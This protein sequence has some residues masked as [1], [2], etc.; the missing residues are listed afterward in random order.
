M[1]P[2]ISYEKGTGRP[3]IIRPST[4]DCG[5][6]NLSLEGGD[7]QDF[8]QVEVLV[9]PGSRGKIG[10][11][12]QQD[13]PQLGE[14]VWFKR[15]DASWIAVQHGM[16]WLYRMFAKIA[17]GQRAEIMLMSELRDFAS[18]LGLELVLLT[19]TNLGERHARQTTLSIWD[20]INR[21]GNV[22][23]LNKQV[24]VAAL[25]LC[26]VYR[27]TD[28]TVSV[29][30]L[31]ARSETAANAFLH[32]LDD[33]QSMAPWI[34]F[35]MQVI[36]EMAVACGRELEAAIDMTS[37]L[38]DVLERGTAEDVDRAQLQ[39][40]LQ[41]LG[42]HASG[43]VLKPFAHVGSR[44]INEHRHLTEMFEAGAPTAVMLGIARQ[45]HV[46]A[47]VASGRPTVERARLHC[48]VAQEFNNGRLD[49]YLRDIILRA[50]RSLLGKYQCMNDMFLEFPVLERTRPALSRAIEAI[51]GGDIGGSVIHLDDATAAL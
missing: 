21:V 9:A 35:H 23:D 33:V 26:T 1:D 6:I 39:F 8:E 49:P 29:A 14:F 15:S 20:A 41:R 42:Q 30:R 13:H 18:R 43:L 10:V 50:L 28:G 36:R 25:G 7:G 19:E 3:D 32:R 17:A 44:L 5:V 16:Y 24:G 48:S 11:I 2:F 37:S 51:E 22:R 31:V 27:T 47:V 40:A 38:C 12:S 34:Q 46:G 45:A 4:W